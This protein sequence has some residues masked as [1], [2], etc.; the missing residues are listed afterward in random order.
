MSLACGPKAL[1]KDGVTNLAHEFRESAKEFAKAGEFPDD[2]FWI[3][4]NLFHGIE[5]GSAFTDRFERP[6]SV[7]KTLLQARGGADD[8]APACEED[9]QTI[10]DMPQRKILHYSP[11]EAVRAARQGA[12]APS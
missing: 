2:T 10:F 12:S 9:A 5:N 7:L 11:G 3:A 8:D 4:K 6:R 1:L